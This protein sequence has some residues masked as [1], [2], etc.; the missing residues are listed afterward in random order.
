MDSEH[1][2][3]GC[4]KRQVPDVEAE[5]V[6][7][8]HSEPTHALYLPCLAAWVIPAANGYPRNTALTVELIAKLA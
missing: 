6:E 2:G 1:Q 3:N 5:R 8:D 7:S 4:E